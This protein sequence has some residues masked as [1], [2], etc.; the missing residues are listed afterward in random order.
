MKL[1]NAVGGGVI[2]FAGSFSSDC[3]GRIVGTSTTLDL[4]CDGDGFHFY[5]TNVYESANTPESCFIFCSRSYQ[6]GPLQTDTACN[7]AFGVG[8][9]ATATPN[10]VTLHKSDF[11]EIGNNCA[12]AI[13]S[14][15]SSPLD[16]G[17]YG[18]PSSELLFPEWVKITSTAN[19]L[20]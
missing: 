5:L 11:T 6:S 3:T 9:G 1:S 2:M 15:G 4:V 16:W 10:T 20:P 7:R 18:P 12:A 14:C 8:C 17:T 13:S 19:P